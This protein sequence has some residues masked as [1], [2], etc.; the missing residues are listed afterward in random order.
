M[1][2]V[3]RAVRTTKMFQVVLSKVDIL[4]ALRH[5][6]VEGLDIIVPLN[7]DVILNDRDDDEEA[8]AISWRDET[9][10]ES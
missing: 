8:V 4:K 7:A 1:A 9:L 2:T 10:E 6:P 3:A 5:E